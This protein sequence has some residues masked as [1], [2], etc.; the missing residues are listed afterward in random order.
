MP[1]VS[2]PGPNLQGGQG[3]VGKPPPRHARRLRNPVDEILNKFRNVFAPLC[4]AGNVH[5]HDVE[6]VKQ[7]LAEPARRDFLAQIPRGGRDH[8]DIDLNVAV[9]ADPAEP[10]LDK[11][12]Q[13]PSLRLARHIGNLVQ[14]EGAGMRLF[15][16]ADFRGAPADAVL[17]EQLDIHALRGHPGGADRDE[18][19]PGARR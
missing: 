2:G 19:V 7:I 11:D 4:K 16:D 15:K 17:A 5:G 6:P 18:F 9:A 14:V 13:D 12:S 3:V 8:P 1:Q 10:L